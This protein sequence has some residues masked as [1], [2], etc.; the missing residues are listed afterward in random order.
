MRRL[1]LAT[2]VMGLL[3][4]VFMPAVSY[5]QSSLNLYVGGFVNKGEASRDRQD[6]LWNDLDFLSFNI[7]DFNGPTAG[8]EYLVGL[9]EYF[10]GGLGVGVYGRTVPSVYAD[11]VNANG[12]ELEQDLKLRMVPFT[13]TVRWLPLGHSAGIEPYI[14]AG[15]AVINYR[16]SES[17]QFVDFTDNSIFR[18]TFVGSGTATGPTILGGVRFPIGNV[19]IG[20]EVRWQKAL[21][22][23]PADQDF[24]GTKIDLGG[25]NYLATFKIR[26]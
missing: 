10:D 24:A 2:V 4:G 13:A 7:N 12:S 9:G 25:V 26:F 1:S 14:G 20:G 21:G 23:L 5:A 17:G 3:A 16:Y 19:A 11:F 15:V 22:D 18:D 6:V 8:A